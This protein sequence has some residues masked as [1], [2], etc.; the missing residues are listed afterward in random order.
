[1]QSFPTDVSG[2]HHPAPVDSPAGVYSPRPFRG[3]KVPGRKFV[4]TARKLSGGKLF[5]IVQTN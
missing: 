5:G 2:I 3:L 4:P 1:M